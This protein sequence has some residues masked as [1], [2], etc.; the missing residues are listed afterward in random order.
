MGLGCAGKGD[1]ADFVGMVN[2][3]AGLR[4]G[5]VGSG[6][7]VLVAL[8]GELADVVEAVVVVDV[9]VAVIVAA[10]ALAELV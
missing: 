3:Q 1:E 4:L 10:A 8:T 7:A 5:E 6:A 2:G 9:A